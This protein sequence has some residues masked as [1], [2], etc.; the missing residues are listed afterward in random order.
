MNIVWINLF[1]SK[2]SLH[3][4]LE[5]PFKIVLSTL[6]L[7]LN[8]AHF[9]Q[10]GGSVQAAPVSGQAGAAPTAWDRAQKQGIPTGG[11]PC[12]SGTMAEF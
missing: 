12:V 11:R 9:C 2:I 4:L 6:P 10:D 7:P 1:L 5:Y 3:E 8:A